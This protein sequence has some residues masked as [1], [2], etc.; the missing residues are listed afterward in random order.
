VAEKEEKLDE[1]DIIV[2]K[3]TEEMVP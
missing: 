2:V 1:E 3:K